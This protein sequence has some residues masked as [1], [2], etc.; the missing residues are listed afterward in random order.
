[1]RGARVRAIA[2]PARNHT[3]GAKSSQRLSN[4]G[5]RTTFARTT[6]AR[7]KCRPPA[8]RRRVVIGWTFANVGVNGAMFASFDRMHDAPGERC[9]LARSYYKRE[10][11]VRRRP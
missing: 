5:A 3:V 4:T 1:M 6:F 10:R 2:T 11:R 7:T 9:R 8:T